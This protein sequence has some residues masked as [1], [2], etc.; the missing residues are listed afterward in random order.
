MSHDMDQDLPP[1]LDPE[2]IP[3]NALANALCGLTMLGDDPY[4]RMQVTNL[5]LVDSFCMSLETRLRRKFIEEDSTP[6]ADA[7]FLAAQS[8]MWLFAAYEILRT[9]R[10]RAKDVIKWA[11]NSGL[12]TKI[13]EL[14]K[15]LG[16]QHHGRQVRAEQLQALLNEPS[17]LDTIRRDLRRTHMVF[18]RIEMLRISLAKHEDSKKRNS[19]ANAPGIGLINRWC[20]AIDYELSIGPAI[21]GTISR[22][23]A[24]DE[25]RSFATN[26]DPPSDADIESFD[27]FMKGPPA[28]LSG[29]A[30]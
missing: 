23:D 14:R 10:Q 25:I 16:Y 20:G 19:I 6:V 26:T 1:Y 18:E 2:E 7:T 27:A 21:L 12:Q 5:V 13:T 15:D 22:R 17:K 29:W 8:Q 3:P 9:W 11:D 30:R 28:D 4:L 24:A